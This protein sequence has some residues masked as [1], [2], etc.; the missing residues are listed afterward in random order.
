MN[1][2][3]FLFTFIL[4]ILFVITT[5][6]CLTVNQGNHRAVKIPFE[7]FRN[8]ADYSIK[9]LFQPNTSKYLFPSSD[10]NGPR[11]QTGWNKLYGASRCGYFNHHHNDS[12]R[13][14]WRRP[15][16]C[17]K[18]QNGRVVGEIENCPLKD[19]IEIAAYAYDQKRKPFQNADLLKPFKYLLDVNKFYSF[20]IVDENEKTRYLLSDEGGKLIESHV[21]LHTKC[22]AYERGFY[23]GIYFGGF[24]P[25]PQAVTICYQF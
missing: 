1:Q 8:T 20:R 5:P 6:K 22:S 14:V 7:G 21:I 18:F 11:C 13:F 24:C 12:D 2:H 17:I 9:A 23:L 4:V 19:K 16:S 25:A 10:V 3:C 15:T